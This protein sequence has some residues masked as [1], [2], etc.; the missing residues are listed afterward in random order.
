MKE[1]RHYFITG[2][3]ALM[4]VGL[5]ALVFYLITRHLGSILHPLMKRAPLLVHWPD[6]VSTVL[7]FILLLVVIVVVGAIATGVLGRLVMTWAD[8]FLRRLPVVREIYDAARQL[9]DAVFVKRSALHRTVLVEYPSKGRYAIGFVISDEPVLLPDGQR[10]LWVYFGTSP[11]PIDGWRA[12]VPLDK[13]VET[14][15]SIG[16]GVKLVVSGGLVKPACGVAYGPTAPSTT[17]P[18]NPSVCKPG[19]ANFLPPEALS[20]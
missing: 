1:L 4:P 20:K 18:S 15:M 5:T 16:E 14:T 19:N 6:W 7:G 11:N 17:D 9:T 3:A 2:I 8:T 12:M 13:M 10:A